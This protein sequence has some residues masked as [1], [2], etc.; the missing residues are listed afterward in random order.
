M[1][2]LTLI[3]ALKD[4]HDAKP[5]PKRLL[6]RVQRKFL[7]VVTGWDLNPGMSNVKKLTGRANAPNH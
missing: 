3:L 6:Q 2:N 5:D 7:N 4:P 1:T